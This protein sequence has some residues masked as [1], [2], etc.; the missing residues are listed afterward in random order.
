MLG[1]AMGD[2]GIAMGYHALP[3][4]DHGMAMAATPS[5]LRYHDMLEY[6]YDTAMAMPPYPTAM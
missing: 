5:S 2:D 6:C 4:A 3:M 1:V